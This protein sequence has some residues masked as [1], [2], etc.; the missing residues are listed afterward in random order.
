LSSSS[1]SSSGMYFDIAASDANEMRPRLLLDVAR[2]NLMLL[3]PMIE[4]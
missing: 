3:L 2:S 4:Q 1:S